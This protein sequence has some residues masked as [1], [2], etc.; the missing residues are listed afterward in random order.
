MQTSGTPTVTTY[1]GLPAGWTVSGS[2]KVMPPSAA[3]VSEPPLR[4]FFK[5]EA[6]AD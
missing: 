4:H 5:P 2:G 3:P 6:H 1:P